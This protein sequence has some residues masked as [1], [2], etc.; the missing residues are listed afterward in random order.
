MLMEQYVQ[1]LQESIFLGL[2]KI[3]EYHISMLFFKSSLDQQNPRLSEV[4]DRPATVGVPA[5]RLNCKTCKQIELQL[6]NLNIAKKFWHFKSF[7][8]RA[9]KNL[10]SVLLMEKLA[11]DLRK[12]Y[13]SCFHCKWH[14]LVCS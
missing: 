4:S 14:S 3:R 7:W 5:Q 8:E 10:I 6:E 12:L 11:N 2:L 13:F 1:S 9:K